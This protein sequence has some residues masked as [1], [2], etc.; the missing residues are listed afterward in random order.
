MTG[1]V[2]GKM[3]AT[4]Q[5]RDIP[6]M[7]KDSVCHHTHHTGLEAEECARLHALDVEQVNR[8]QKYW[9]PP[10]Y[11]AIMS[12]RRLTKAEWAYVKNPANREGPYEG[13]ELQEH[14]ERM[15]VK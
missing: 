5:D 7:I 10:V 4:L 9:D 1:E 13:L 12:K 8:I 2:V 14:K 3:M 15:G 6:P 11:R